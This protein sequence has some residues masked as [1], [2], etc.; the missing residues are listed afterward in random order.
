MLLCQLLLSRA[1]R[2][3]CGRFLRLGFAEPALHLTQF[4][5]GR[6]LV[7]LS[8]LKVRFELVAA[9]LGRK[10]A[11]GGRRKLSAQLLALPRGHVE[12]TGE[13]AN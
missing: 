11:L 4:L 12:I 9:S 13:C 6:P 10:R 2:R 7:A 8:Q 5:L 3:L 1:G